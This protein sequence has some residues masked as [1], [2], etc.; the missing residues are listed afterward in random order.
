MGTRNK[1]D[2]IPD[3]SGFDPRDTDKDGKVGPIE[4]LATRDGKLGKVAKV[5]N[6]GLDNQADNAARTN[7]GQGFGGT[8]ETNSNLAA[9]NDA[10]QAA[11][12]VE[13][14]KE[15]AGTNKEKQAAVKKLEEVNAPK[16][17]EFTQTTAN[18]G[19]TPDAPVL[20]ASDA[21]TTPTQG[22]KE[23][24]K[25]DPATRYKMKSILQAY[26]DG[27]IDANT[28]D[29][30]I[31]DTFSNFAR[32]MGKDVGNVA[33]AYSGGT[34]DNERGTSLWDKRNQAMAQSAIE[35]EQAG[36]EGSR[37]KRAADQQ[38]ASLYA[39]KLNNMNMEDRR[40]LANEI[41][42]MT[43]DSSKA[44][45]L[46]AASLANNMLTGQTMSMYDIMGTAGSE[47][48]SVLSKLIPGI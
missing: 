7:L 29:Y 15:A 16:L 45:R 2:Y 40:A 30:M 46:A 47:I 6:K 31:L 39:T 12:R 22:A 34:V 9:D 17:K 8:V 41:K 36:V 10:A 25:K 18:S 1:K 37:E 26:N 48:I 13:K 27:D 35:G 43:K 4:R 19:V 28:R 11:I 24:A 23:E 32:N 20:P 14:A 3:E 38:A 44:V 42:E 5:I 33:A 21:S